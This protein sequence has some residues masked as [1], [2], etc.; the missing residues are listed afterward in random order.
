[1][2]EKAY[3]FST[4]D[5]TSFV[6]EDGGSGGGNAP[7]IVTI[8]SEAVGAGIDR[9]TLDKTAGEIINAMPNAW[10]YREI[11]RDGA[12]LYFYSLLG[13]NDGNG[14]GY[15]PGKIEGTTEI[16]IMVYFE[17]GQQVVPFVAET[18][19]DYPTYESMR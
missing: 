7:L 16:A 17:E 6:V 4:R 15:A 1:M 11:N 19:D 5:D 13:G 3:K 8:S 14:Y 10:L 12:L 2:N 9:Y 18:L